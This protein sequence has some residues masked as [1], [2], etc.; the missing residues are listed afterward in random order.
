[1]DSSALEIESD[2]LNPHPRGNRDVFFAEASWRA[3][4]FE[5]LSEDGDRD[6]RW[7]GLLVA[8]DG[9][10]GVPSECLRFGVT[11]FGRW[12]LQTSSEV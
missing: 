11:T 3:F 5:S 6:V 12:P 8:S 10:T 4:T 7:L 2:A 1:V 9:G